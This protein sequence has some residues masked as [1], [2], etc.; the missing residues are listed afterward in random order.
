MKTVLKRVPAEYVDYDFLDITAFGENEEDQNVL[1]YGNPCFA[2]F[3]DLEL[4]SILRGDY[5]DGEEGYD[6]DPLEM[7]QKFTGKEWTKGRFRGYSQSDW[8]DVYYTDACPE[9][10]IRELESFYM[11]KV[12]EFFVY[13]AVNPDTV[14]SL[15]SL[16]SDYI[17]YIPHDVVWQGKG[18]ICEYAGFV[19]TD[20]TVFE[21]DGYEKVYHYKEVV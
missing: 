9:A 2:D 5:Y 4:L 20:T 13:S 15:N 19:V 14:D 6:Y 11:G 3:G 1:I 17:I 10:R 8:Q 12:D 21:D 16:N 7:L 18:A